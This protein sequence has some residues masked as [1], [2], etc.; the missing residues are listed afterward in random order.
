MSEDIFD[1]K[2]R[3]L[4]K[5]KLKCVLFCYLYNIKAGGRQGLAMAHWLQDM[6]S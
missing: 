4:S 6:A 5:Q 2:A 3:T 1:Y